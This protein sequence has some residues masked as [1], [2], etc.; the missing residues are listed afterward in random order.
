[1]ATG[2]Y[3]LH[4]RLYLACREN[5]SRE[6]GKFLTYLASARGLRQV[7]R[8]GVV[9]ARQNAREIIL[10]TSPVGG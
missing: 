3:P 4:H 6:G 9:P 10:T 8:A 5:G 2:T 7:E 1:V